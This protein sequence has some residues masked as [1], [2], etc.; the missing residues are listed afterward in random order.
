ME[1][2]DKLKVLLKELKKEESEKKGVDLKFKKAAPPE[3]TPRVVLHELLENKLNDSWDENFVKSLL[4]ELR[5]K[6]DWNGVRQVLDFVADFECFFSDD[7]RKIYT[8]FHFK[9]DEGA[10]QV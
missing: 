6:R 4:Q 7:F 5:E 2:K 3:K 1:N 10:F 8:G 9:S